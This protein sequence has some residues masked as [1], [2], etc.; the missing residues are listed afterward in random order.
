MVTAH[1]RLNLNFFAL[2]NSIWQQFEAI[3][4]HGNNSNERA[5]WKKVHLAVI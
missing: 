3:P 4:A 2:K 1:A 5:H